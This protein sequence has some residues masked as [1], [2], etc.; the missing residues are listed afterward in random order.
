MSSA[1]VI[2]IVALFLISVAAAGH[3]QVQVEPA[4]PTGSGDAQTPRQPAAQDADSPKAT[5]PA[6]GGGILSR[7]I[8]VE[9]DA[10]YAPVDS[11]DW[12]PVQL[13]DEYPQGTKIITGVRSAVKLQIGDQEPYSCILIESVGL[14]ILSETAIRDDT[15]KVRVGVG[16]GRIR[17]GVA[18]GGL[19]SDFTVDSPVATLSKRG[20]WNFTLYYERDTDIFEIGLLD[21]GLV[22]ALSRAASRQRTMSPGEFVTQAMRRWL[23]QAEIE[24]NVAIADIQGQDDIELAFNR[25]T[26]DGLGVLA[27]GGGRSVVLNL[28]NVTARN[29]FTQRVQATLNGLNLPPIDVNTP[30]QLRPEGFFGTGRGDELINVIIEAGDPMV[31]KGFAKPGNYRIRRAALERWVQRN[32]G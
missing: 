6:A 16:Y 30:P 31:Q 2:G 27:P 20:T 18:E 7:V 1:R 22:N 10:K 14:T 12:K 24:R 21:R 17:A 9:G 8:E 15:K 28:S 11:S 19:K 29:N 26:N 23:D 5:D 3:A 25:I 4:E 32:P 13:G